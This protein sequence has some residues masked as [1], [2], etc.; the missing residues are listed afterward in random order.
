MVS[1]SQKCRLGVALR[2]LSAIACFSEFGKVTGLATKGSD[3][4]H[5]RY[6]E[7]QCSTVQTSTAKHLRRDSEKPHAS[8]WGQGGGL[9]A[10]TGAMHLTSSHGEGV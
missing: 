3:A 5:G 1:A 7:P 2:W 6:W 4:S 9:Q 8:S 10:G